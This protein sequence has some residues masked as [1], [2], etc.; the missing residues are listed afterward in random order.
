MTSALHGLHIVESGDGLS[1]RFA[2][3]LLRSLGADVRRTPSSVPPHTGAAALTLLRY[4]DCGKTAAPGSKLSPSAIAASADIW[5]DE[6]PAAAIAADLAIIAVPESSLVHVAITPFGM[7]GPCRDARGT[8]IVAAALGGFLH[9]C[10]DENGPPLKNGGYVVEFQTGLFAVLGAIV[11][12]LKAEAGGG[13]ARIEVSLLESVIA[14]QERADIAWTHQGQDWRR[15]RRHEVAHPFT[16]FECADGFVSL[17]IGTPRHWQSM[18]VLIGK[19]EWGQDLELTM[20]RLT[21]ADKIDTVLKP[22]LLERTSAEIVHACQQLFIPC[23]PVLT[24]T[25]VLED[26]HLRERSFF[27]SL[28][29]D[30]GNLAVPGRPFRS[31]W[32]WTGSGDPGIA[33]VNR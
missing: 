22:W 16:I 12:V 29:A 3:R 23:G 30:F 15:T 28:P 24:A 17:A 2:G 13:G 6:R 7:T 27:D 9:L 21:N 11:G 20:N 31:P 26:A 14:F 32:T 5:L 10:G 8:G 25:G 4:L 19:P 33:E 18:C 1:V